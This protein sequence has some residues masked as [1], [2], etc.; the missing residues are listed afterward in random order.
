VNLTALQFELRDNIAWI[1][2]NR[3]ASYNAMNRQMMMELAEVAN[4]CA[5]EASVRA[6]VLTGM[7]DKAFC[8]GGDVAG[9]HATQGQIAHGVYEGTMY[10]HAAASRFAWMRAPLIAAV[11]GVA[12]GAGLSAMA[13]CDL[14][15]AADTATFTSAYTKIGFSPDGSSTWF[16]PRLIGQRR[17]MEMYLTNRTLTATEAL[18]W[19]LINRVVPAG[20]LMA[21]VGKL[22]A[23]LAAGPTGTYGAV[24][25]LMRMSAN[26][27]LESQMELESRTLAEMAGSADAREGISA[28]V[29]K[30]RPV[31]RGE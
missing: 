20:D 30:R 26:D 15:I 9:F 12:A 31:F 17:A 25:K 18:E 13:F 3:P 1:T 24:K 28:F 11:N 7:G 10:L 14:A 8:A 6:A 29:E 22:A 27:S 2:F 21:E 23:Q 5:T 16:L 4:Y 19:G